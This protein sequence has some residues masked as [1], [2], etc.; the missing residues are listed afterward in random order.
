MLVDNA[1][2]VLQASK[3]YIRTGKFTPEEAVLLVFRDFKYIL[4]ATTLTTVWA[5][6]PLLLASGI[7]G[8][9]IRSIPITVS[10]TLLSSLFVAYIINHPLAVAFERILLQRKHFKLLMVVLA[11]ILF[12]IFLNLLNP[13]NAL[14]ELILLFI[15]GTVTFGLFFYYRK[16]LKGILIQ[17]EE[18]MLL[19]RA[20]PQVLRDRMKAKY[21]KLEHEKDIWHRMYAGLVHLDKILP[22]YEKLLKKIL[23]SK[24][25]TFLLLAFTFMMFFGSVIVAS[26]FLKS[27]FL[28][29][30]DIVYMYVNIEGAPGLALEK[31]HEV[32]DKV[33]DVLRSEESIKSF[34][35]TVGSAGVQLG[36][37]STMGSERTNRA[38]A[39]IILY[40]YADRPT[41]EGEN[42][43]AKS[44]EIAQRLREKLSSIQDADVTVAEVSGGPPTGADFEARIIGDD[45]SVLEKEAEKYLAI[46]KEIPGTV[47]EDISIENSPGE[48]VIEF[49]YNKLTGAGITAM[50]VAQTLRT[51]ISGTDITTLYQDVEDDM[52]VIATFKETRIASIDSINNLILQNSRGQNFRLGDMASISLSSSLTRIS[53]LNGERV[54]T[55]SSSV[56]Q[57]RLPS[58]I[59]DDFQKKVEI[60]PLPQ[61]YEFNYGGQN[62]EN[63]ESIMSIFRA[64]MV[65][66]LLII[67][68]LVVQYNSFTKTLIVLM[69]IPLA[70]SG[71]F[72]GLCAIG[73]NLSFPVLIGMLSLF[74]IVI[75]NAI[76]LVDKMT[77]NFEYGLSFTESI[78]D[79]A[80]TRLEAIFL[81]SITTIIGI[82]PLIFYDETW[83]GLGSTLVFGLATSAFLT[84]II[85]PTLYNLLLGKKA[86]EEEKVRKLRAELN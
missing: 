17:N 6:L 9:F 64:M 57:P 1:I 53:R 65:A 56:E 21:V 12:V 80:K 74:G 60:N 44:Y 77:S 81:T 29:P 50:Q 83:A 31:T 27:E 82:V 86:R 78:I 2:V 52:D 20:N 62:E 59:L 24:L 75:N 45:L 76:I 28:P 55:I 30:T 73:L 41:L 22:S 37:F 51:A 48:F 54:V 84:L 58:E 14:F 3:Q 42:K 49:D 39:A 5:F 23:S 16:K 8:L 67:I 19:E 47:N 32:A 13:G 70:T 33:A 10:A 11:I 7:T 66:T 4:L 36:S 68:T 35:L 46:L 79:A 61:G 85:I 25:I 43:P 18:K 26:T 40:D 69:T 15:F 72:Y 38:Q 34:S 71:V 63:F